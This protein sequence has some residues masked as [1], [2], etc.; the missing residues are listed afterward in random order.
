[1]CK[2]R[3]QRISDEKTVR[4]KEIIKKDLIGYK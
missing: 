4:D 3:Q 1:M 2:L